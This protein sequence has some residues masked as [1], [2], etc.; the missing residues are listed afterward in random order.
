VKKADQ[1]KHDPI[2][3]FLLVGWIIMSAMLDEVQLMIV[4]DWLVESNP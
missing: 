2:D 1:R 3:P 4:I